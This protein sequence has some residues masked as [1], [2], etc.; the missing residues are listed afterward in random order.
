MI[1][2]IDAPYQDVEEMSMFA[3]ADRFSVMIHNKMDDFARIENS[4][5]SNSTNDQDPINQVL[6]KSKTLSEK[7]A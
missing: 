3:D 2:P 7:H 1:R 5:D 6:E 4:G